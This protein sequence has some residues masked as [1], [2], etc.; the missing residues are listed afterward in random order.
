VTPSKGKRTK[1]RKRREAQLAGED[2]APRITE[3]P[4]PPEISSAVVIG[5]NNIVRSLQSLSR[6][7][8]PQALSKDLESHKNDSN[9]LSTPSGSPAKSTSKS[10]LV[11]HKKDDHSEASKSPNS[12]KSATSKQ[13]LVDNLMDSSAPIPK[14][15]PS[16]DTTTKSNPSLIP[17]HFSAIF[18]PAS[19]PP[20]I[21]HAHLPMLIFTASLAHPNLP[22]TRLVQL[23]KGSDSR[24]CEALGLPRVSFVGILDDAPH[25]KGLVD[26]VRGNVSEIE[27]PWLSDAKRGEYLGVKINAI[28]TFVGAGKKEKVV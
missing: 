13:I 1:K 19:S 25:S 20:S 2:A 21:I 18:V 4:T 23:P 17:P 16:T 26:L 28:E 14:S 27:I 15:N 11:D 9:K 12:P 7:S 22:P 8:K 24:L 3:T 10:E 6:Q 5:L